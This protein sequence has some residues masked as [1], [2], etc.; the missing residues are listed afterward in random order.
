MPIEIACPGCQSTLRVPDSAA[1]KQA[2]C[3]QC[4]QVLSIPAGSPAPDLFGDVPS[5]PS[6]A[7]REAA[8]A[9]TPGD[10]FSEPLPSKPATASTDSSNPYAASGFHELAKPA[11][12]AHVAALTLTP[13]SFDDVFNLTW[14]IFQLHI[15][16]LALVGLI[17]FA[18]QA[19]Q[20]VLGFGVNLLAEMSNDRLIV[21]ASN[22]S[23]N[24]FHFFV[25]PIVTLG[26]SVPCLLL[27]RQ[28]ETKPGDF[29]KFTAHYGR[30]LLKDFLYALVLLAIV[31]CMGV[32]LGILVAVKQPEAALLVGIVLGIAMFV[33]F[34]WLTL[35]FY[36][37]N[38]F[39]I[40]RHAGA[41]ESLQLSWQFM[42][43]NRLPVFGL[44]FVVGLVGGLLGCCTL[45]LGSIVVTPFFF[46]LSAV[47]Y[48]LATGQ[49]AALSPSL[50]SA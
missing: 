16:P 14:R 40:D 4:Q 6:P 8:L 47:T 38:F 22:I 1:G 42:S 15:G 31:L 45:G 18:I 13:V 44:T 50:L 30:C 32:P 12:G 5:E 17:A 10:L 2:R 34:V 28:G 3:P 35:S 11:P 9:S 46:L 33:A 23:V 41:L 36:L 19:V 48:M 49:R 43:G 39:I 26:C 7:R 37:A 27:L 24:V 29:M 20:Q 25:T 21:L